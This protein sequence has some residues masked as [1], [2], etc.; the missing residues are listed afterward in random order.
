MAFRKR[1]PIHYCGS[2]AVLDVL[3][4][5]DG[6][7]NLVVISE[8]EFLRKNPPITEEYP[9]SKELE[10]GVNLK[11]IPCG[12][13]IESLDPIDHVQEV[14]HISEKINKSKTKK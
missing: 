2:S 8:E 13:L 4:N 12:H 1:P 10:A 7:R 3:E 6:K 9:L 5:E 14:E 11:E